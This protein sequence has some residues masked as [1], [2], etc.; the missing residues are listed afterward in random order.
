ML[1]RAVALALTLTTA[2]VWSSPE[3]AS[4]QSTQALS[5]WQ[6][7]DSPHFEIHYLPALAPELDRVV[8]SA[9]RAYDRIS[10]QLNFVFPTKVPLVMFTP[11]GSMTRDEFG[12]TQAAHW[13]HRTRTEAVVLP[14][15]EGDA[16][17]AMMVHE[18][19]H[20]LVSEIIWPGRI[21]DGGLPHWV[22]E[23]IASYMV[24]VWLDED[25]RLMRELVASRAVPALSQLS[26]SGGFANVRVNNAL[27]HAA[28]DYIE[29]RWGPNSVRRFLNALI[30]PRVSKTY[31]AVFD[32][33]P[34]EF[35]AAFRQYAENRFRRVVR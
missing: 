22:K 14:L 3:A 6:R 4:A 11:S 28:F 19:T 2:G 26:S 27:G 35:D 5:P 12:R 30:M 25:E 33:T 13:S 8:R 32:L 34:A 20:L 9:E 16:L 10:G 29:S 21:G 31:D 17:D 7:T 1:H 24:G 18:L 23:G 15:A